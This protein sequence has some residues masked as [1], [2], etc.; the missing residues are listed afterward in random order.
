MKQS[1]W[2]FPKRSQEPEPDPYERLW[3]VLTPWLRETVQAQQVEYQL[4]S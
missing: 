3:E 4:E 2:P 1:Q